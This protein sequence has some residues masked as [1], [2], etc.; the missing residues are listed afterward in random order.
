MFP[1]ESRAR[2]LG[3]LND[4]D[5]PTPFALP[6]FPF[7]N[8]AIVDTAP[9]IVFSARTRLP[10]LESSE[11]NSVE[12]DES[13][14]SPN[15]PAKVAAVPM[16]SVAPEAP[17]IEPAKVDTTQPLPPP[18][19]MTAIAGASVAVG[20]EGEVG[21]ADT[22]AP[23]LKDDVGVGE[24]DASAHGATARSVLEPLS[25]KKMRPRVSTAMPRGELRSASVP[26]VL[27]NHPTVPLPASV[28]A[29][30]PRVKPRT[31]ALPV[32][33]T[34][35]L[36]LVESAAIP[37]AAEKDAAA[38][39]PFANALFPE[40]AI[41]TTHPSGARTCRT[42]NE[43]SVT[44]MKPCASTAIP[45]GDEK[46]AL[47]P[48]PSPVPAVPVPA[49][50]VVTPVA[51]AIAR[52]RCVP[53]SVTYSTEPPGESATPVGV[54]KSAD[55]PVPSAHPCAMPLALPPASVDTNPLLALMTRRRPFPL[56]ATNTSVPLESRA[57]PLGVLNLEMPM[58][59]SNE[60]VVPGV[61]LNVTTLAL[62]TASALA[63][64]ALR[65]AWLPAS[66]MMTH[67][68]MLPDAKAAMPWRD[69]EKAAEVPTPTAFPAAPLPASVVTP[70]EQPHGEV[71]VEGV[72]VRDDVYGVMAGVGVPVGVPE[73]EEPAVGVAEG[74]AVGHTSLR[75]E[76]GKGG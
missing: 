33:A 29:T 50:V 37:N 58:G 68:P 49:T 73:R 2:P 6:V 55:V 52:S 38:P 10:P 14:A 15:G 43:A 67:P 4:A 45:R 27:S 66:A 47:G 18:T 42:R 64:D 23:T 20:V 8:P 17:V 59:P 56:S 46:D 12:V 74:E 26:T 44:K 54:E 9:V 51:V 62:F 30:P 69:D 48:K 76:R 36:P 60:P 32:S 19:F 39:R 21:V 22:L 57:T 24:S 40:P 70:P 13:R 11:M 53:T 72:G 16:P 7:V 1:K 75:E 63:K 28:D 41:D 71:V 65:S 31:R 61:P 3:V 34:Y 35:K 5:V 25:V